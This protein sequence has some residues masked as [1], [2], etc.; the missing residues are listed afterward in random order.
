M[1]FMGLFLYLFP[2]WHLFFPRQSA[3]ER[4]TIVL[5]LGMYKWEHEVK[6]KPEPWGLH[7][8]F[9]KLASSECGVCRRSEEQNWFQPEV[10]LAELSRCWNMR[11]EYRRQCG[12]L[13][14]TVWSS[15]TPIADGWEIM[16]SPLPAHS[17]ALWECSPSCCMWDPL[18]RKPLY[19]G[20]TTSFEYV[21][22]S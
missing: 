22:R 16:P 1:C 11:G 2:L 9:Y 10:H 14:Y 6:Y 15:Q 12:H 19:L 13:R 7:L 17:R 4:V 3:V 5:F 8:A 18:W 21:V 20:N